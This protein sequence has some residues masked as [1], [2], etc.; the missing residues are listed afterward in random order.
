MKI[1]YYY[2][3]QDNDVNSRGGGVQVYLKNVIGNLRKRNDVEIFTL[4][5]GIAY[6]GRGTCHVEELASDG[7]VRRFQIVN[8]P[9]LAPSKS[10]FYD[11][12]I[13][14]SDAIV[15]DVFRRFLHA[16]GGVDVIHFQSLE[17]L[18]QKVWELKEE[19]PKTKFV[20]SLHNYQCFCPQVNL[21]KRD[22]V[23]CDDFHDGK[24]CVGCL[25][26]YPGSGSF[27]KYYILDY[28]LRKA[29]MG[30]YSKPLLSQ[31]KS[32]YARVKKSVNEKE[33]PAPSIELA[34]VF[35]DFRKMNV[36]FIN[37]Y[38]DDVLCVSRRV[39]DIALRMGVEANKAK[40]SYIG[41]AFAEK[42]ATESQYP[43]HGGVL[44]I[45]YMGYMRRD[46][47]FY[48]LL[49]TLE[50]MDPETAQKLSVVVAAKWEDLDVVK[51]LQALKGKLADV[52]LYDGYTHDQ[53]PDII[54]GVHLGIVPVLWEDNLPQVAIEFSAM[55]IPVL[56]SDRGGASELSDSSYFVFKSGD[57]D[58]FTRKIKGFQNAPGKWG[59]AYWLQKRRMPTV[60][61]H[62]DMLLEM[63]R[64]K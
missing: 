19:F 60:Q 49:D 36:E 31:V 29:G 15:K 24:D 22:A 59:G 28:Y 50:K 54:E 34:K 62:C 4:S 25:G 16:I 12:G 51:R 20:L 14:L 58:D 10:S 35:S 8:S 44:R 38:A 40:V 18:T 6:D 32:I 5:S 2:W 55:G 61:E 57:S 26:A 64:G 21:W 33:C 1:L 37:R 46:K 43:Y 23:C 45:A 41:S 17:G 47:G 3:M 52:I 11:Q 63:Y 30:R 39:R 7:N 9:M 42:Q 13:Y 53:I 56:A 27:K 48:F